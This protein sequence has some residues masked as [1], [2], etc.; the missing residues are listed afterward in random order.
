M[1]DTSTIMK[2]KTLSF[3]KCKNDRYWHS[4]IYLGIDR[5]REGYHI[6]IYIYD[7]PLF[8]SWVKNACFHTGNV[9]NYY[10]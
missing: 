6:D 8:T 7:T 10:I 4:Y 5:C 1:I 2:K 3:F 9:N